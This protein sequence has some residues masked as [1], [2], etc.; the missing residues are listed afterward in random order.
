LQDDENSTDPRGALPEN[1]QSHETRQDNREHFRQSKNKNEKTLYMINYNEDPLFWQRFLQSAGFYEGDL[2]G[3]FGPQSHAAAEQ[4]EAQSLE[5]AKDMGIFDIRT[6]GN[7]Q[8][9]NP[10]RSGERGNL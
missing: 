7:I 6:E 10:K 5:I 4:F 3:D 2:D 9:C 1:I 8:L